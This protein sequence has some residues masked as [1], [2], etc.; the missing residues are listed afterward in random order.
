MAILALQEGRD[1]EAAEL[2]RRAV[3]ARPNDASLWG[4]LGIG[5][6][7]AQR[8]EEA[9]YALRAGLALRPGDPG[10]RGNLA[11]VLID[12]T[13]GD[14]ARIEME[15]LL[16]SGV[17]SS[18]LRY[19]VGHVYRDQ[20]RIDDAM[21]QCRKAVELAPDD[22]IAFTNYLLTLNYSENCDAETLFAEHRRF[23]AR[24]AR[25]YVEPEFDRTWPRRLRIGYVSPD[26]R[27]HV[28]A[29]FAAPLLA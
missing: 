8:P 4:A 13:S 17:E 10:M 20:A 7:Q 22:A 3:E 28:V 18:Q 15:R 5:A 14:E 11:A 9:A 21:A 6:V 16:E 1:L 24:F 26:F 25:P 27:Q 12:L 19:N 23:G 2:L 29:N